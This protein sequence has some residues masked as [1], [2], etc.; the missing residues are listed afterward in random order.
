MKKLLQLIVITFPVLFF[1][2]S[3]DE[4]LEGAFEVRL[5]NADLSEFENLEA[6]F[7]GGKITHPDLQPGESTEALTIDTDYVAQSISVT[8]DG[9]TLEVRPQNF[10]ILWESPE[11]GRTYQYYVK[12]NAQGELTFSFEE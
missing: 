4:P 1:S 7:E 12:R 6:L 2:C 11:A 5:I 3:E 10:L 8:V 9:E